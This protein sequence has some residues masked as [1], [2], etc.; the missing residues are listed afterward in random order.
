MPHIAPKYT[1]EQRDAMGIG[2]VDR[3]MSADEVK[4]AAEA[5][6]L[7][8]PDGTRLPPFE[9]P[10]SSIRSYARTVRQRRA[11][12]A[13]SEAAKLPPRDAV[14]SVRQRLIR[15]VD[16]ELAFEE[17]KRNGKRD[18]ER[19]RQL[20]RAARE[21]AALP[22]LNAPRPRAPDA[23]PGGNR[24]PTGG[25]AGA[26]LKAHRTTGPRVETQAAQEAHHTETTRDT[27]HARGEAQYEATSST[28]HQGEGAPGEQDSER[29]RAQA[30]VVL[31]MGEH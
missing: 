26:I 21:A 20:G 16:L 4:A 19:I 15:M 13:S 30:H 10:V 24:T 31:G 17:R 29:D 11:G 23:Q 5:G 9:A 3:G 27:G 14:E 2:M 28:E 8:R 12:K 1:V 22:E 6:M 7:E 18:L 25:L